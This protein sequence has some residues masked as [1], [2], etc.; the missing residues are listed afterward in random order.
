MYR[1]TQGTARISRIELKGIP[2]SYLRTYNV[3]RISRIELKEKLEAE[4]RG[5]KLMR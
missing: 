3:L 4:K 5:D 2:H 1:A